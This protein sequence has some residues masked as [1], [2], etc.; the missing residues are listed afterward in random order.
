MKT[1]LIT[2]A[3]RGIGRYIA[4][5]AT[6]EGYRV[7][8]FARTFTGEE[9]YETITCDIRD[10]DQVQEV[11]ARFKGDKSLYGLVNAAGI[12]NSKLAIKYRNAEINDIFC[13]NLIG[14][15]H[16]SRHVVRL[17]LPLRR[18]RVVN[19]SSIA[20]SLALKGDSIYSASKA[21]L[22]VFSR[23]LA[24]E[25]ADR[26]IT[27]NCISPGPIATDMTSSLT[28][29]QWADLIA[30]QIIPRKINIENLWPIVQ[31][32]LSK[33]AEVVTGDIIHVGGV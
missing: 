32:L 4:E 13:T 8:G 2:G 28:D 5:R 10:G 30:R 11:L 15:V 33:E 25:V 7:I 27:V 16:F 3:S 18:G 29:K 6:E 23:A 22:E 20:S 26:G 24:R 12:L 14:T 21:G 17:L 1:I 31:F 9:T 19:F